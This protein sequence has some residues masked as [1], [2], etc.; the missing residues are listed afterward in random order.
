VTID[1][2]LAL[3]SSIFGSKWQ[4]TI[5]KLLEDEEETSASAG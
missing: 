4:S 1:L 5:P 3:A 2:S